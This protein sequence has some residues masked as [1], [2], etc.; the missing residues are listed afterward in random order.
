[1]KKVTEMT[2]QFGTPLKQESDQQE[3]TRKKE[4]E[5][6]ELYCPI[7]GQ[8]KMEYLGR[9]MQPMMIVKTEKGKIFEH[10]SIHCK[11]YRCMICNHIEWK[12]IS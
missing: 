10:K 2:E 3:Y 5:Q 8:L 9:S 6:L 11:L 1:V 7:C 12:A 4:S